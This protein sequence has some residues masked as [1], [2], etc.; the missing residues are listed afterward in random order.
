MTDGSTYSTVACIALDSSDD[1]RL[2]YSP[3]KRSPEIRSDC[4]LGLTD[5]S[6]DS[7]SVGIAIE[8]KVE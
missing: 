1:K 5:G 2:P 4:I 7:T 3:L 6:T 8:A